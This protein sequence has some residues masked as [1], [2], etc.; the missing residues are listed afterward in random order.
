[1]TEHVSFEVQQTGYGD[2]SRGRPGAVLFIAGGGTLPKVRFAAYQ[3]AEEAAED[4]TR[5][6]RLAEAVT[7]DK[8]R[9]RRARAASL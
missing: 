9:V 8:N 3:A 6:Q 5:G 2:N 1:M 4:A 7:A